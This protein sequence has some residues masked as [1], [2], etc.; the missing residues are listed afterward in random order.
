M[1]TYTYLHI[2]N[3]IPNMIRIIFGYDTKYLYDPWY[4][5][6]IRLWYRKF[7]RLWIWFRIF[8]RLVFIFTYTEYDTEYNTNHIR[9][10][11][12][13]FIRP[14]VPN[15]YTTSDM[16]SDIYTT[17]ICI[18]IYRIWYRIWYESYLDMIPNVY[19]TH[20]TEY[21]YDFGYD[22][23]YLYDSCIN[24][25]IANMIPNMIRIIFG[26]D[27]KYLYDPWYQIF[28][29][30]WIWYRIFIRLV[31][32]FTYTEYDTEYDTN[33]I[34][35]WYRIF[36]RL[37]IWYRICIRLSFPR[38]SAWMK[39]VCV[40]AVVKTSATVICIF[41]RQHLTPYVY[42]LIS[43]HMYVYVYIYVYKHIRGRQ[44]SR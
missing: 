13:L 15:I 25:H 40:G 24:L 9:I 6:C 33:H 36:L 32:I 17:R 28:K 29:R 23:E 5:I 39:Y 20:G 42:E 4:R 22:I 38:M 11:Y 34:W 43:K 27:T 7:I 26:Y 21:V 35:I 14:M 3:I 18:Y 10:W 19:T 41:N 30:L 1:G 2:P 44:A 31:S 37:R 12:R 16:I 8:I